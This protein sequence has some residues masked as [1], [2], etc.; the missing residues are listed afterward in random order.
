MRSVEFCR[1]SVLVPGPRA[2]AGEGRRNATRAV[3]AR[4]LRS[5]VVFIAAVEWRHVDIST[6]WSVQR[7]PTAEIGV[8]NASY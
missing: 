8:I 6:R 1:I 3:S 5:C 4:K 2:Q 7:V